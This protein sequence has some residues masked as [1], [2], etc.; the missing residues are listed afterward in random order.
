MAGKKSGSMFKVSLAIFA[1]YAL[2]KITDENTSEP[3][4]SRPVAE[5]IAPVESAPASGLS[6]GTVSLPTVDVETHLIRVEP[7]VL[8]PARSDPPAISHPEEVLFVTATNLNMRTEPSASAAAAG[9]Y[10][11]GSRVTGLERRGD[12][13]R[14]RTSDRQEGW[15]HGG[16]LSAD[17]PPPPQRIAQQPQSPR[18][19]TV[20]RSS[21]TRAPIRAPY[22][23]TC[24]C[25]YD[26]ARNGS[27][28]GG[29]SAWSR[30]GGRSPV[31]YTTD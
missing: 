11:N 6:G 23:G 18:P 15:M 21:S 3:R 14:V 26:R 7:V 4:S 10:R 13:V 16:H 27:S 20:S 28:C 25:P 17:G 24:D 30:P 22:T 12:W 31:C 19:S 9:T 8:P 29:R 5:R 2:G 1:L